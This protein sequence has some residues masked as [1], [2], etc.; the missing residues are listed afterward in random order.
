MRASYCTILAG[1][2]DILFHVNG[3]PRIVQLGAFTGPGTRTSSSQGENLNPFIRLCSEIQTTR[4]LA[5]FGENHHAI[6]KNLER[7]L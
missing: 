4:R 7:K 2:V 6:R 3:V 1:P 5:E